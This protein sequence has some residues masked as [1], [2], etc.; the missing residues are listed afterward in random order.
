MRV[1][2]A[3]YSQRPGCS[4]MPAGLRQSGAALGIL[5]SLAVS[6]CSAYDP[7]YEFQPRPVEVVQSVPGEQDRAASVLV[8][9]VG[10]R[11]R[12]KEQQTPAAVE[13][14]MRVDNETDREVTLDPASLH[15]YAANLIPFPQPAVP[16]GA[17]VA[18]PH[19]S[20]DLAAFFPFPDGKV[21]GPFDLGGLSLRW[22]LDVGDS[23]VT[24]SVTFSR[25]PD[26]RGYYYEPVGLFGFGWGW[27]SYYYYG[28]PYYG[29]PYGPYRYGGQGRRTFG[30]RPDS[31]LRPK[32]R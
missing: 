27:P 12:D 9:V 17:L 1:N 24:G 31:S 11:R 4:V 3:V 6:A 22:T 26:E 25:T 5:C 28:Y 20:G 7:R 21:P 16:A 10:V 8:S 23:A 19:G 30:D 13:V 32:T 14:R 29:Y 2:A 15:L 18:P